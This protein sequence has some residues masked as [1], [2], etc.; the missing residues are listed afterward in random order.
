MTD[1]LQ[2]LDS[3]E[4]TFASAEYVGVGPSYFETYD[5]ARSE[6]LDLVFP[7]IRA[8]IDVAKAAE[9]FEKLDKSDCAIYPELYGAY[10]KELWEA[11]SKLRGEG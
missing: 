10:K 4:R 9:A 7:N 11:L 1:I 3:A 8:L 5:K 6:L 2:Q